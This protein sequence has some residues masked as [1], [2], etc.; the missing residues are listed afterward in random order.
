M[1]SLR[2]EAPDSYAASTD[3]ET[4]H[5]FSAVESELERHRTQRHAHARPPPAEEPLIRALRLVWR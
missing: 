3:V 5:A 1:S 2:A 4:F